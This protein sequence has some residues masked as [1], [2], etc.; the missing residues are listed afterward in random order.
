MAWQR[1]GAAGAQTDPP[2]LCFSLG[3]YPAW[4]FM[5]NAGG[6]GRAGKVSP[7]T[8]SAGSGGG[9]CFFPQLL[10]AQSPLSLAGAP[11]DHLTLRG[12]EPSVGTLC[13]IFQAPMGPQNLS[14]MTSALGWAQ[15]H[16]TAHSAHRGGAACLVWCSGQPQGRWVLTAPMAPLDVPLP[17]EGPSMLWPAGT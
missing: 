17:T 7:L 12:H 6:G 5:Q 11:W 8:S 16:S 2:F 4:R 15:R 9:Q 13:L 10:W 14:G 3:K 1:E